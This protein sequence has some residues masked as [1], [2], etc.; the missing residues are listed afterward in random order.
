MSELNLKAYCI[1]LDSEKNRKLH[2][3]NE[4][5]RAGIDFEFSSA[6]DGR[7][8]DVQ[9]RPSRDAA[10]ENKW[11]EI[12]A[13]ALT[14]GFFNRGTNSP[15][16]ACAQSHLNVWE[17]I[18]E[19]NSQSEYFLVNEDDFYVKTTEGLAEERNLPG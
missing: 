14:I 11:E 1:N 4:Y 12:D 9:P 15:E 5:E 17:K 10:E 16:R 6:T 2:C 13:V 19:K 18:A 7:S 3:S 8:E